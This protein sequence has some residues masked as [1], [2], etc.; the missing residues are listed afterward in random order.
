[1]SFGGKPLD[2]EIFA[3]YIPKPVQFQIKCPPSGV[4]TFVCNLSG[5]YG[6]GDDGDAALSSRLLRPGRPRQGAEEQARGEITPLHQ[7]AVKRNSVIP[8]TRPLSAVP[9]GTAAV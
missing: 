9:G 1:M 3:L 4:D 7:I 5:R 8:L 6:C 2:D